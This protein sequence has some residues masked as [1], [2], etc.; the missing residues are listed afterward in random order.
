MAPTQNRQPELVMP[1][2]ALAALRSALDTAIGADA[3]AEALRAAG[4]AAGDVFHDVLTGSAGD[5]GA[6]AADRFWSQLATLFASR[7]WGQIRYSEAHPGVGSLESG[8]WAESASGGEAQRPSCHF[9]TGALANV[10][11]RAA[12]TSVAVM[13]VE[14]RARG[15]ERCRFLFGGAEAVYAVYDRLAAGDTADSAIAQIG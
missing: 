8:D 2:A 11:G 4:H 14:C 13:E 15:D 10:L 3:A 9:T 6:V 5:P 12:G 1:V 7:G